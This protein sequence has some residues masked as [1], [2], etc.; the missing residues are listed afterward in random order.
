MLYTSK[1]HGEETFDASMTEAR[2]F[3]LLNGQIVRAPFMATPTF[4]E[5]RYPYTNFDGFTVLQIPYRR[6]QD[7]RKFSM[8]FFHSDAKDGLL[9][10]NQKLK[11]NP[12]F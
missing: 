4:P 7:P 8:Y 6:G 10:L 12:D 1:D 2:D 9:D 5:R 11:S 3:H